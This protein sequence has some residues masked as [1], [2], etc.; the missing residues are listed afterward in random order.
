MLYILSGLCFRSISLEQLASLLRRFISFKHKNVAVLRGRK[1]RRLSASV[2]PKIDLMVGNF[3]Q[4]DQILK[5]EP[6]VTGDESRHPKTKRN[7]YDKWH[8]KGFSL[9]F[10]VRFC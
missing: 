10:S 1:Q 7:P 3:P 8:F 9:Y 6:A 5:T 2:P 4:E